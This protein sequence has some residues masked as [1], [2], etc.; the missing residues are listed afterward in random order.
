MIKFLKKHKTYLLIG[1][2]FLLA[3]HFLFKDHFYVTGIF[4]YSFPLGI[5]ITAV[6]PLLA[7]Y[8][9]QKVIRFALLALAVFLSFFF[10]Q[11]HYVS[12]EDNNL[13]AANSIF[14]WNIADQKDYNIDVLEKTLETKNIDALFFVEVMHEDNNFNAEFKKRLNGYNIELLNGNMMVAA[15]KGITAINYLEDKNNYRFNHIK[16]EIGSNDY[17]IV[18]VDLFANP[19]HNKKEA[20]KILLDYSKKNDIDIILGDFNTPYESIYF[21][22]LKPNY[23][24]A[25]T[26]RNGF[27]ATWPILFP[28][29]ELDQIWV[30]KKLDV[31]K[32]EKEFYSESDHAM[33]VTEFK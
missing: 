21:D 4:F 25:R 28:L 5:L 27:T 26:F 8:Y 24:S 9:N 22:R 29:W 15:K 16:V 30:T 12:Y 7:L 19:R 10:F 17:N 13:E 18:M 11:N 20:F 1:Y 23:T 33:L 14:F 2:V 6:F 3:I 32:T 31:L